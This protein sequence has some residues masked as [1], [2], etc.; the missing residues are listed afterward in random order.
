MVN[1]Y[2]VDAL[3]GAAPASHFENGYAGAV[4]ERQV[5]MF[6]LRWGG[7]LKGVSKPGDIVWSRVYVEDGRLKADLGLASAVKLPEAETERRWSLTDARWSIMHAVL[8]GVTRDQMMGRHKANHIQV[9]YA[10]DAERAR[11]ALEAK[12]ATF[13]ALGLEVYLYG[14]IM[15]TNTVNQGAHV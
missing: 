6:F 3:S 4:S 7:T 12:A 1:A 14:N 9:A 5:P 8:H 2:F 13:R 15:P 11:Q 10:L